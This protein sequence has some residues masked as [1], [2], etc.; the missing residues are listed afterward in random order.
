MNQLRI[1]R[2]S[3]NLE[4]ISKLMN[5][6]AKQYDCKVTYCAEDDTIQFHGKADY[7]KHITEQTLSY[8]KAA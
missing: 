8:F 7:R 3:N 2:R 1:V 6:V 5:S 4:I